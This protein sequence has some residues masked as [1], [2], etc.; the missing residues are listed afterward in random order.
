MLNI[1]INFLYQNVNRIRSKT[2]DLFLS[3]LSV[4][5]DIICLTVTNFNASVLDGEVLDN[6][7][8]VFRRDRYTT[9]V[10]AVKQDG[11]GVLVAVKKCFSVMRQS[12]WDSKVEDLWLSVLPNNSCDPLVHICTCYLY[13]AISKT[14]LK[15]FY[16]NTQ[17]IILNNNNNNDIFLIIGDFNTPS[18]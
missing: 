9:S 16:D 5:F 1:T 8:N 13:P 11:G 12:S 17:K 10:N 6:R 18:L 14:D 7:Y 3:T 2:K 15:T 4:D